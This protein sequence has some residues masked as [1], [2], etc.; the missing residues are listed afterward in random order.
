MFHG[1]PIIFAAGIPFGSVNLMHGVDENESKANPLCI[2]FTLLM[3][4]LFTSLVNKYKRKQFLPSLILLMFDFLSSQFMFILF[5]G[6]IVT[7]EYMSKFLVILRF[8]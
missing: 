6:S 5:I 1:S 2:L 3:C 4:Y 8:K 7:K